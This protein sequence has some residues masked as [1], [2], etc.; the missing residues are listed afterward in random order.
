[1]LLMLARLGAARCE[2]QRLMLMMLALLGLLGGKG[3]G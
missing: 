2:G 3:G 1:M